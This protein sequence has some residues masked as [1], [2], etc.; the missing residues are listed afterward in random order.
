M[1]LKTEIDDTL[2]YVNSLQ[3]GSK[4]GEKMLDPDYRFPDTLR[5]YY[6]SVHDR[7][8]KLTVQLDRLR[9]SFKNMHMESIIGVVMSLEL[10]L[11]E[12]EDFMVSIETILHVQLKNCHVVFD[13]N[14]HQISQVA[15]DWM[16]MSPHASRKV[17]SLYIGMAVIFLLTLGT[18]VFNIHT[19][20][21]KQLKK[22]M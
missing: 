20:M 10:N 7:T 21:T 19:K 14:P 13:I 6:Q 15:V 22:R 5:S 3:A 16:S 2:G 18:V 11:V 9:V 8:L 4:K 1:A 17:S 12:E